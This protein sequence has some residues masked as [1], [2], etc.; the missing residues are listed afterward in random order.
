[1]CGKVTVMSDESREASEKTV[2]DD[3]DV[4]F[5]ITYLLEV[6]REVDGKNA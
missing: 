4:D 3:S 6:V 2:L 5:V 1:M